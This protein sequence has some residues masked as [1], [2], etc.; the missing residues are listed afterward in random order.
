M[1][2]HIEKERFLIIVDRAKPGLDFVGQE[3]A[4]VSFLLTDRDSVSHVV[5]WVKMRRLGIVFCTQGIFKP[6]VDRLC[7][8]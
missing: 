4:R 7:L 1:K 5:N 2:R 3:L 8:V 6:L